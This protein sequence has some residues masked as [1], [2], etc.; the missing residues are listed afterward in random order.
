MSSVCSVLHWDLSWGGIAAEASG[1]GANE[2]GKHFCD[3]LMNVETGEEEARDRKKEE[4][5]S[6]VRRVMEEPWTEAMMM[7]SMQV[8]IVAP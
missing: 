6:E 3:A 7:F 1:S 5:T 8:F 4:E 2:R